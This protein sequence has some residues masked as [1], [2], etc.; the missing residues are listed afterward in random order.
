MKKLLPLTM[1][2]AGAIS[3]LSQGI[4]QFQNSAVFTTP[5]SP[6]GSGRLVYD[7]GSPLNSIT[8]TPLVGTNWVAEL[9]VGPA[10]ANEASLTP[11]VASISRF[12]ASTTVNKG[13]WAN[14]TVTGSPNVNLDLGVPIGTVLTLQVRVWDYSTS[15]TFEG[16]SGVTGFSLLFQFT[17]ADKAGTPNTWV[18]EGFQAWAPVP[19][20]SAIALGVMGV[21][22]LLLIRRVKIIKR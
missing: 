15:P 16:A 2:L 21:A 17:A 5:D 20:P 3:G 19:E 9:Y 8:G 13:K 4:V 6:L 7:V 18:M 11:I 1:L 14:T 22:G 12:R 10:G